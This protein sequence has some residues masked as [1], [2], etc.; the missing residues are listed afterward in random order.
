MMHDLTLRD[1][2]LDMKAFLD[3][4]MSSVI[5]LAFLIYSL[6]SNL[7]KKKKGRQKRKTIL[8]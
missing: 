7:K 4:V 2:H 6:T 3:S 8:T 5:V 1:R